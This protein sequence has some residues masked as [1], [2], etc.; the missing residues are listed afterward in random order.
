MILKTYLFC[1]LQITSI[2]WH[3]VIAMPSSSDSSSSESESK[4]MDLKKML[5]GINLSDESKETQQAIAHYNIVQMA[6]DTAIKDAKTLFHDMIKK[7]EEDQLQGLNNLITHL[8]KFGMQGVQ[9]KSS[10]RDDAQLYIIL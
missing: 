8:K 3:F 4:E 7:D 9:R 2:T 5:Q 6:K 1:V 10:R